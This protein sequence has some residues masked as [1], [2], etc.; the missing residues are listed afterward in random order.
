MSYLVIYFHFCFFACRSRIIDLSI[1]SYPNSLP[2]II[3]CLP[4]PQEI[5]TF[6]LLFL[7]ENEQNTILIASIP[8][9]PLSLSDLGNFLMITRIV[10]EQNPPIVRSYQHHYVE[11]H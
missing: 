11:L 10:R 5:I 8:G 3:L 7:I 2:T 1:T 6:L 9:R 4:L